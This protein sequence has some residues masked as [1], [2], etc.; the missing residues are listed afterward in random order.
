MDTRLALLG[1]GGRWPFAGHFHGQRQWQGARL[2]WAGRVSTGSLER[3][4]RLSRAI[5][6]RLSEAADA[7]LDRRRAVAEAWDRLMTERED[8]TTVSLVLLLLGEDGEGAS[9]SAVGLS[10]IFAVHHGCLAERWLAA[11]HPVLGAPGMPDARPGALAL[12]A[13]PPFLVGIG[14]DCNP[15]ATPFGYRGG[16]LMSM[17]GQHP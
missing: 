16:E 14:S 12:E 11:P 10:E 7:R 4:F 6:R 1:R 15:I 5:T 9:L 3:D 17:S 2:C 13:V 8:L